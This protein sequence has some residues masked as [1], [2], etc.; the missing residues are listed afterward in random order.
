[1]PSVPMSNDPAPEVA[2]LQ[3]RTGRGERPR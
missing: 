1:M 3:T 2:A